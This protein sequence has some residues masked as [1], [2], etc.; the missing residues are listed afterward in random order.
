MLQDNIT[1]TLGGQIC[2]YWRAA[3]HQCSDQSVADNT[4]ISCMDDYAG[5]SSL[6]DV[7]IVNVAPHWF[8]YCEEHAETK[9]YEIFLGEWTLG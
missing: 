9:E 3:C 8:R 4:V 5:E 2:A 7:E 6:E 1:G